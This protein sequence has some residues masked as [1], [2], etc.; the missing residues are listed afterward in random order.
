MIDIGRL[1]V[2]VIVVLLAIALGSVRA[3]AAEPIHVGATSPAGPSVTSAELRSSID[4]SGAIG[5]GT[6]SLPAGADRDRGVAWFPIVLTFG[7]GGC[8]AGAYELEFVARMG[9]ECPH[10]SATIQELFPKLDLGPVEANGLVL[11]VAPVALAAMCDPCSRVR[12]SVEAELHQ[13]GARPAV[14]DV[15]LILF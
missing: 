10:G 13:R 4:R 3:I 15:D 8:L 9:F 5:K 2:A 14:M 12:P 7:S 1:R 6:A 11:I